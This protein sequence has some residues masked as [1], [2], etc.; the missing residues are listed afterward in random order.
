MFFFFFNIT[1]FPTS[2]RGGK[3]RLGNA[4]IS[5]C[6]IS[7]DNCICLDSSLMR[8]LSFITLIL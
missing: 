3:N 1:I 4:E 2:G 6:K 8:S 5:D 7:L